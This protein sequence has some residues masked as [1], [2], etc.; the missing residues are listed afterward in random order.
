[1]KLY[2]KKIVAHIVLKQRW[3]VWE[4]VGGPGSNDN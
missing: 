1:M 2:M 3:G 4:M